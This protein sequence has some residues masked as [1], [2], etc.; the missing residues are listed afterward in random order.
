MK[1]LSLHIL[2]LV[3][4]SIKAEAKN[5]K[6]EIN[7]DTKK[8]ILEIII[9]DDGFGMDCNTLENVLNPFYTTRTTRN[10]GL[11]LSL[12]KA[13]AN[14]CEGDLVVKSQK[15]VG[16]ELIIDFKYS[17]ID[18]APIGNMS[19][20]ITC[21][22][23]VCEDIDILYIHKVNNNNFVF[24]TKKIKDILEEVNLNSPDIILWIKDYINENITELY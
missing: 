11:G 3:Q 24:D 5:I 1:E 23:N 14:R 20:T 12:I 16:T 22:L 18:R 8:D 9:K 13:A 19:D 21:L 17:H 4:N 7:E 15:N 6:I 10:V 2:D